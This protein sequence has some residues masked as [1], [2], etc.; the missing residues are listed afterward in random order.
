ML[1]AS[2]AWTTGNRSGGALLVKLLHPGRWIEILYP[3]LHARTKAAVLTRPLEFSIHTERRAYRIELTRRSGHLL[4]DP[5][6]NADVVCSTEQLGA[7]LVG[8]L[9]VLA[10]RTAGDLQIADEATAAL[11][12]NLFPPMPYWQ[13]EFDM[14]RF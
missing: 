7:L 12:A 6:P 2:G 1:E 11:V 4:R 5:K 9:D 3:L 8:N 10:A 14:L 13:S